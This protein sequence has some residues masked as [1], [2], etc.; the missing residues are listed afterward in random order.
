MAQ[1]S[2]KQLFRIF[3]LVGIVGG[4][5]WASLSAA[6][7]GS[8]SS[9]EDETSYA[10]IQSVRYDLGSKSM[11]G[12]FVQRSSVCLVTLMIAEKGDPDRLLP[13]TA[14][15]VRL[16]LVPGQIAGLDSEEGRSLNLKCGEG[17]STLTVDYG[18]RAKLI[19]QQ[20]LSVTSAI[21]DR[22]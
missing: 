21:A 11:S 14:A 4:A 9:P 3:A 1:M 13:T 12:Y 18:E 5:H 7:S 15:R 17:A 22:H 6:S 8:P 19:A 10:P 20:D 16:V 2:S